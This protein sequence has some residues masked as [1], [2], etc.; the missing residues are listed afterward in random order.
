M[1]HGQLARS[2]SGPLCTTPYNGGERPKGR[3]QA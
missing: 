3:P 2:C 1:E